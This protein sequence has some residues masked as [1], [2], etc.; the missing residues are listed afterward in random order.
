[1]SVNDTIDQPDPLVIRLCAVINRFREGAVDVSDAAINTDIDKSAVAAIYLEQIKKIECIASGAAD[2]GAGTPVARRQVSPGGSRSRGRRSSSPAERRRRSK[3]RRHHTRSEESRS[4]EED[5]EK[6]TESRHLNKRSRIR[7]DTSKFAFA[8]SSATQFLD[9][10]TLGDNCRNTQDLAGI[11]TLDPKCALWAFKYDGMGTPPPLPDTEWARILA[12]HAVNLDAINT[13]AFSSDV[14]DKIVHKMGELSI[15][16]GSTSR[17]SKPITSGLDWY[18]TFDLAADGI[19]Y[20]YPH[21]KFEL[22]TYRE[23]IKGLF[24]A[25]QPQHHG[26]VISLDR[27]IRRHVS[28]SP[29]LE[30]S[31]IG[32]FYTLQMAHLTPSGVAVARSPSGSQMKSRGFDSGGRGEICR[33]WNSNQCSWR[34]C[35]FKH[36]CDFPVGGDYCRGSHRRS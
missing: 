13:G 18:H 8:K 7:Q 36:V 9:S 24:S 21:R 20:A 28:E 19:T 34:Q 30:L 5:D 6:S 27:A 29:D 26:A 2:R 12:N 35:K 22:R 1:M 23:Y 3:R 33:Q 17:A 4:S 11:Y 15:S 10:I 14:D 32:S 16:T 25:I 31:S